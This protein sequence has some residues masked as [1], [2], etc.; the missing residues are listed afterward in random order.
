MVAYASRTLIG[1]EKKCETCM[2][3]KP[4]QMQAAGKMLTQ[5]PE[6]PWAT[7]CADFVGLLLRFKHGN[8]MLLVRKA[9]TEM[10]QKAIRERNFSRYGV[11]KVMVTDNG[12]QFASGS[13]KKFLEE[14]ELVINLPHR[15][16]R[17]K[18]LQKGQTGRLRR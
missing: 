2:R 16:R 12:V 11:P 6:E 10:L 13:F 14:L 7:V 3:F 9:T 18:T 4:S 17:R 5:I 8:T 15:T 1:A